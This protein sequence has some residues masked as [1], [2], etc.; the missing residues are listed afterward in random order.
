VIRPVKRFIVPVSLL[1]LLGLDG[2]LLEA[3]TR[4]TLPIKPVNLSPA[5]RFNKRIAEQARDAVPL[6]PPF[7]KGKAPACRDEPTDAEVLRV[8][9]MLTGGPTPFYE[10]SRDD[11]EVE[12]ERLVNRIDTV[13]F[14]PLVGPARLR[15]CHWKCTV[16]YTETVAWRYPFFFH[17]TAPRV[18]VIYFDKDHLHVVRAAAP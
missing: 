17:W 13:R 1:M 4:S 2:F 5:E 12:K 14:F 16:F 10:V 15:R 8:L 6:R 11:V 3:E 9:D 18:E 7:R